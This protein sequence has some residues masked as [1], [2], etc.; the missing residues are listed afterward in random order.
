MRQAKKQVAVASN[1][2]N[3]CQRNAARAVFAAPPPASQFRRRA[4]QLGMTWRRPSRLCIAAT[5]AA[6]A[7]TRQTPSIMRR[8]SSP[9]RPPRS[10]QKMDTH[11]HTNTR[12]PKGTCRARAPIKPAAGDL[13]S[14][15]ATLAAAA[16]AD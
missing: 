9:R 2:S 10:R 1:R 6:A 7:P 14:F 5:A 13:N 8:A 3:E 12:T 11:T 16:A 4:F 15:A